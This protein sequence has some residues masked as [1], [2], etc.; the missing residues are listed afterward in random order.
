MDNVALPRPNRRRIPR[1]LRILH[2]PS[3]RHSPGTY[4]LRKWTMDERRRIPGLANCPERV[5]EIL[6]QVY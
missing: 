5:L 1:R 3:L 2:I 6:G 4:G